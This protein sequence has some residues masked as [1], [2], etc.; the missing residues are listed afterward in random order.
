V[1]S[2]LTARQKEKSKARYFEIL[3]GLSTA[4]YSLMAIER[5]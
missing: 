3:T 5:G 2:K 1:I 4:I